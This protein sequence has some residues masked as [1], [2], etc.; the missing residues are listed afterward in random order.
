MELLKNETSQMWRL[1]I[2]QL[3]KAKLT[4][5]NSDVELALEIVSMERRVNAF[6][7]KIESNC[8]NYIALYNPVAVDLRLVLSIMKICITLERIGDF[9]AGIARHVVEGDCNSPDSSLVE[10]LEIEKMFD[11]VLN[12][13]SDSFVAPEITTAEQRQT[14]FTNMMKVALGAEY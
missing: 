7:L 3:E 5:L 11:I 9:A 2:S 14:S 6:E 1:V 12:M 13:L 8:E 4:F 10:D